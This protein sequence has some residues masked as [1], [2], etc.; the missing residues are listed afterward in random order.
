MAWLVGLDLLNGLSLS[1]HQSKAPSFQG[2]AGVG[3]WSK[4]TP[5]TVEHPPPPKK[6]WQWPG[7]R[8]RGGVGLVR[9]RPEEKRRTPPGLKTR[10]SIALQCPPAR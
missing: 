6:G 1:F 8:A 4:H 10:L 9:Q 5:G 3:F 2:V 7:P